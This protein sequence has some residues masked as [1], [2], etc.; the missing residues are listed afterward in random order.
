M[1]LLCFVDEEVSGVPVFS[2]Q[3]TLEYSRTCFTS[4]TAGSCIRVLKLVVLDS[5]LVLR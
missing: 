5:V 2:S 1:Q 3:I 4:M